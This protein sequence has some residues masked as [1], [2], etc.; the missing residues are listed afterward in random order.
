MPKNFFSTTEA[1]KIVGISRIA[2]FKKIKNG[3][4]P[5]TQVGR[6]FIIDKKDLLILLERQ[7][8][9]HERIK[10]RKEKEVQKRA[11]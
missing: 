9:K 1:A 6:N 4:L 11:S 10:K 5:A 3:S 8:K 7:T 2:I